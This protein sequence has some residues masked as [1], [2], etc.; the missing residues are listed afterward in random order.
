[1]YS[2]QLSPS[3]VK[4]WNQKIT[5]S[6]ISVDM[7]NHL[8]FI[9]LLGLQCLLLNLDRQFR[10]RKKSEIGQK[11][12]NRLGF[13]FRKQN[14]VESQWHKYAC[15]R[16]VDVAYQTDV[17]EVFRHQIPRSQSFLGFHNFLD[18]CYHFGENKVLF[19]KI[20]GKVLDLW[21][22]TSSRRKWSKCSVQAPDPKVKVFFE[23]S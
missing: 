3:Q 22:D 9:F 8:F 10:K 23:I 12:I 14:S 1:M 7:V 2:N 4:A 21:L 13:S 11:K 20:R 18:L 19:V 16:T 15:A 17:T 6:L 5:L